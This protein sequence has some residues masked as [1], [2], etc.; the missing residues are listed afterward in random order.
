MDALRGSGAFAAGDPLAT[1]AARADGRRPGRA[2]RPA[3]CRGLA[4]LPATRP[5][6]ARRSPRASHPARLCA[7]SSGCSRARPRNCAWCSISRRRA[8]SSACT[9]C[10]SPGELT[11]IR[12]ADLEFTPEEAGELMAAAGVAVGSGRPGAACT[13]D[14]GLGGGAPARRD[15]ARAPRRAGAGSWPS[16]RAASGRSPTTCSARCWPVWPPEVRRPAAA[17]LHPRAGQRRARRPADRPQRRRRGCCTSSRR[18]TR[19][20]W[21][22]TS[23]APGSATTTCSPT[24]CGSSCAAR[25]PRR[26]PGCTGSRPAGTPSTASSWTRSATRSSAQDWELAVELLGRHWVHLVARR[27]GGDARLAAGRPPARARRR[28]TPRSP[29]SRRPTAWPQLALERGR[30]AAG[31]GRARRCRPSRRPAGVRV[32]RPRWR[33]CSCSARAG[34]ATS[35]RSSTRRA[36]VLHPRRWRPA[37]RRAGGARADEPRH[38]ARRGRCA[39]PT[40]NGTWSRG[41]RSAAAHRPPVRGGRLPRRRSAWWR[42]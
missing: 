7:V 36:R 20:S 25:R 15:V 18:P 30:R 11:E 29:R 9:G 27:R 39:S 19:S 14:R 38:R 31:R 5:A 13:A 21:R 40:P 24:C 17:H 34:S 26:S 32:R 23:A 1:L 2:R 35:T 28:A 6:G 22:S 33:P 16:S 42:T 37:G 4:R 12:A 8:R 41:S 3:A 10:G